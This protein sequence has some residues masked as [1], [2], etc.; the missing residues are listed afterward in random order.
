MFKKEPSM[1]KP[2]KSIVPVIVMTLAGAGIC[3]SVVA[4]IVLKV[5]PS[6]LYGA[7][8][9]KQSEGKTYA[10]ALAR[11][12]LAYHKS[13][14]RFSTDLETLKATQ[15][16]SHIYLYIIYASK[17]PNFSQQ[18]SIPKNPRLKSYTSINRVLPMD[19]ETKRESILCESREV[20][21]YVPPVPIGEFACP[22]G[23]IV[24]N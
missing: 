16:E 21:Q 4:F 7:D 24:L 10:G 1:E 23:F 3:A 15:G 11:E 5:V 14:G 6:F 12:Q 2:E 22:P 9:A 17:D 18:V 19:G 8:K 13:K 20:I